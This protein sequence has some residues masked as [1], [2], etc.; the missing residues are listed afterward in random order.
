MVAD[1]R[2]R[3]EAEL[4]KAADETAWTRTTVDALLAAASAEADA[5]RRRGHGDAGEH[6]SGVRRGVQDVLHRVAGRLRAQ[7]NEAEGRAAEIEA[8]AAARWPP[9]TQA[10]AHLSPDGGQ[11]RERWS[12]APRSRPPGPSSAPS[13]APARPR[14]APP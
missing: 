3:S 14:R 7:I 6:L 8:A 13:A 10:A 9:P 1:A 11:A 4:A 5:I 2:T 12:E